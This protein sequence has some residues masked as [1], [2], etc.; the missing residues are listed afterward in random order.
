METLSLV[1]FCAS[2]ARSLQAQRLLVDSGYIP[3]YTRNRLGYPFLVMK[4]QAGL[5]RTLE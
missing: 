3:N 2:A 5:T 4:H 1:S